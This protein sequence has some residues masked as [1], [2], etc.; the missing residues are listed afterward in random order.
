MKVSLQMQVSEC[1]KFAKDKGLR[2]RRYFQDAGKSGCKLDGRTDLIRALDS[3]QKGDIFLIYSVS[4]A[5]RSIKDFIWIDGEVER[6]GALML[7]TK[8]DLTNKLIKGLFPVIAEIETDQISE[9]VKSGMAEKKRLD[10][11]PNL[12]APYG[13]RYDKTERD[14]DGRLL[15]VPINSEQR[16][17][18]IIKDMRSSIYRG[19]GKKPRTGP[20][21]YSV[22]ADYLNEKGYPTRSNT[23]NKKTG[24]AKKWHA[25]TVRN[26][27]E[28]EKDKE[29][30]IIEEDDR[31]EVQKEVITNIIYL[32]IK[33]TSRYVDSASSPLKI[34]EREKNKKAQIYIFPS[35]DLI[36]DM[37]YIKS[38]LLAIKYIDEDEED[39][40]FT[41][42]ADMTKVIDHIK[43]RTNADPI[44]TTV[45]EIPSLFN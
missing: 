14:I 1:E 7:S 38:W 33:S 34:I 27:Y 17:I 37:E 18:K 43:D 28:A 3:L 23:I 25:M 9:R 26:I 15:L 32:V 29:T 20:T 4:R 21:P 10:G 36:N 31:E 35:G 2:I 40:N 13:Y 22:I 39:M 12:H 16:I 42:I 19:T 41:S 30:I 45:E 44:I 5:A 11:T 6:R 8:E 24:E